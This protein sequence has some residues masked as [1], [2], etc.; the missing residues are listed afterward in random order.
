LQSGTSL[1]VTNITVANIN[2]VNTNVVNI[3]VANITV[4]NIN[5]GQ[6]QPWSISTVV[7]RN[8][9]NINV[10]NINVANINVANITVVNIN[11]GQY[12]P[13]SIGIVVNRNVVNIN[14][15]N[16]HVA[17]IN[18]ANINRGQYQPWSISTAVNIIHGQSGPWSIATWSISTWSISTWSISTW[19]ISS[20]SILTWSNGT[21]PQ[22][23]PSY[24]TLKR[25]LERRLQTLEAIQPTKS[26]AGANKSSEGSGRSART[27]HV[28]KREA[29]SMRCNLCK[30]DHLLMMC[31]E[32]RGKTANDRR[33]YVDS[34]HL[35]ANCLGR[36]KIHDCPSK[37][38]CSVCSEKHHTSL[39]DAFRKAQV[40]ADVV[41]TSHV[42]HGTARRQATV[43]LATAR[44]RVSDR[45]GNLQE[46]RA[47]IDQG[48]EA[49][50]VTERLAQRLRL[51]RSHTS[52]AV[53]GVGGKQ[54]GVAKGRVNLD[55][56]SRA[57][58]T[59]TSTSTLILPRLTGYA[60]SA[61]LPSDDWSHIEGLELADP[62]FAS[63]DPIDVL[64]GA[65]VYASIL[66]DGLRKGSGLQPVAQRTMF[67][68]ILSGKIK[69]ADDEDNVATHQC[70]VGESLSSLVKRFWEQEEL[71][72]FPTPLT[73]EERECEEL[74]VRTHT[75]NSDGRYI[76]RLPVASPLP[77]LSE[78][79]AAAVRSLLRSERRF[80]KDTQFRDSYT[81]F[82]C[83]YERLAHMSR[84]ETDTYVGGRVYY[85]PH[86]GVLKESSSSTRLRVVFN[87]SWTIS[88]STSLYNNLL[89][90]KNL[91][92]AL[93]HIL[94]RWRWHRY[95]MA[96]DIEKM[97][98]QIL[99]HNDDRDLQR[100][101]WRSDIRQE[102][103]EFRLTTVTYGL[104]CAPFL[105]VRTLRQLA[106]DEADRFSKGSSVLL[107]DVYVD[108]VLTGAD[109]IEEALQLQTEL[110]QLC[111][112]G[113][114]PLKKWTS[115]VGQLMETIPAEDRAQ[116]TPL[117]WST[118]G[119]NHFTLGLLWS[120]EADCFALKRPEE[121]VVT[122]RSILTQT[123]R[124]FD[125]LGWL[126]PVSILAKITIQ[127]TWLLRLE[128][129]TP[130]PE[131]EAA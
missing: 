85:L 12:Q 115:N 41:R 124:L 19:S 84:I 64:L 35:F 20:W 40:E 50:I 2:V 110:I 89:V 22:N 86:H 42:A 129:D 68:W 7:N 67:G 57:G 88:S 87:G 76:V 118:Q 27:H 130:L 105:A 97:Y 98:R 3:N 79:R 101:L 16:L 49:T 10:V 59:S 66:R 6:Y 122:K 37:R 32:F 125:S 72:P 107:R 69:S 71:T 30:K 96:S 33:Q 25:F 51:P 38:L 117:A 21:L 53:F 62:D 46:A 109:T 114:F 39:H 1:R 106:E 18:V 63:N 23:P 123:A 82:M 65:D 43:P 103:S 95:V 61:D 58:E 52:V 78:T 75:R 17:N 80:L 104:V 91:L 126:T 120:P 90:G 11:R 112:A 93:D 128:W 44:I 48:S 28:Q 92:P 108:D 81:E 9:I 15:I 45:F 5:R 26:E 47:L 131:N 13:W 8:V 83:T 74:Y 100:I 119:E 113:G 99:V 24:S 127:S 70:S 56:W 102:M 73:A 55:V 54:T 34:N 14:V 4:A 29:R 116:I 36:H 31:D 121:E 111:K 77:D 60:N 94:L